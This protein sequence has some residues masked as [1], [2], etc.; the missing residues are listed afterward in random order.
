MLDCTVYNSTNKTP[1]TNL[2][3]CIS[4]PLRTSKVLLRL[5]HDLGFELLQKEQQIESIDIKFQ[6]GIP[7][8]SFRQH[9]KC[10]E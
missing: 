6:L 1:P 8:L 4:N 2:R 7:Y 10:V 5:G 3:V 9:R